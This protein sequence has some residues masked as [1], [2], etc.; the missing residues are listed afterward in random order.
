[1]NAQAPIG[2]VRSRAYTIPTDAPEADGTFAWS[3]TTLVVATVEGGGGT[4]LG[5]TY[6]EAG[7][8]SLIA[9]LLA[10]VVAGRDA[11]DPPGLNAAMHQA[12]RNIG[13][14]GIAATAISALDTAL[15]D[16]KA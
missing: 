1:V 15:W 10:K 12:V 13:R 2:A 6:T 8:A 7:A 16:L 9:G 14:Q 5:Y 3:A 4:G 11:M